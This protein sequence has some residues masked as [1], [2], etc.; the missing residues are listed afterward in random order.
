M[1]M[2]SL[3][4]IFVALQLRSAGA[5]SM[6]NIAVPALPRSCKV[7]WAFIRPQFFESHNSPSK[8]ANRFDVA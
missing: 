6:R 8:T 3:F 5:Y 1:L 4:S 7:D 2:F